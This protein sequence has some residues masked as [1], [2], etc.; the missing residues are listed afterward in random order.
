MEDTVGLGDTKGLVVVVI[1]M[2]VQCLVNYPCNS[3]L[4]GLAHVTFGGD[5]VNLLGDVLDLEGVVEGLGD[6]R[7]V[8]SYPCNL[9]CH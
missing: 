2:Y 5:A 9:C 1:V 4:L 3:P 7:D 6:V 8:V